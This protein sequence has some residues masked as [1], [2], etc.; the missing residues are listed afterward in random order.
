[1]DL[2]ILAGGFATRLDSTTLTPKI[3]LEFNN[4]SFLDH[5]LDTV[6][7]FYDNVIYS[8]GYL[9]EEV[10]SFIDGH[11]LKEKLTY[12]TDE[13]EG[14]GTGAAIMNCLPKVSENFAVM[15]GDSFLL[16]DHQ[17]VQSKFLKSKKSCAMVLC[18]AEGYDDNNVFYQDGLVMLYDKSRT[19]SRLNYLDY[20]L[21][22]FSKKAFSKI[23]DKAK[24][25][26]SLVHKKN[27]ELGDLIG[28]LVSEPYYEIGSIVGQEDFLS[29]INFNQKD[30]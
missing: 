18:K 2:I 9:S 11:P 29:Y 1:M 30:K 14:C 19:S 17:S 22:F 28:I 7:K 27:I 13:I 5:Q 12:V 6:I 21:N 3:M 10:I 23:V 20:G 16:C 26:L 15:Y 4:R 8:L 25:D 24:F